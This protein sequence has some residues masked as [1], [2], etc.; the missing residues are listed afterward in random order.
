M[1]Q[2]NNIAPTVQLDRWQVNSSNCLI[3]IKNTSMQC[4]TVARIAVVTVTHELVLCNSVGFVTLN[5]TLLHKIFT[6]GAHQSFS[7]I[8]TLTH[9]IVNVFSHLLN[10][11][12]ADETHSNFT[13]GK[14]RQLVNIAPQIVG[15]LFSAPRK[16]KYIFDKFLV[17]FCYIK[18]TPKPF[19]RLN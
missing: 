17:N 13:L 2:Y 8:F 1:I 3:H 19:W 7:G 10:A 18:A 14:C 11:A 15:K 4:I 5:F 16:F 6:L 9:N 12:A